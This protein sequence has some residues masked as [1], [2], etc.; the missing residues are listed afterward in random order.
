MSTGGSGVASPMMIA[1]YLNMIFLIM[2]VFSIPFLKPGTGSF[3]IALVAA[4]V[5]IFN[6]LF[7]GLSVYLD[8]EWLDDMFKK[9]FE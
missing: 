5:V 2:L 3:A 1:F 6:L 8:I 7:F 9:L 4:A